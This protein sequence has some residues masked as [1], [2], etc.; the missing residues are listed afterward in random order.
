MFS[1]LKPTFYVQFPLNHDFSSVQSSFPLCCPS[2]V[3]TRDLPASRSLPTDHK[4]MRTGQF[5]WDQ[6]CIYIHAHICTYIYINQNMY[7]YIHAYIYKYDYK[8]D[9]NYNP[10]PLMLNTPSMAPN[11]CKSQTEN[12]GFQV[13]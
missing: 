10:I 7:K 12:H 5:T 1:W 3:E 9:Y 8:Y 13:S 2:C 4:N 6:Y 11:M